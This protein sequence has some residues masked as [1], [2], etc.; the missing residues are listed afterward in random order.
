MVAPAR[1]RA[2]VPRI[3]GAGGTA[4][5]NVHVDWMLGILE[6]IAQEL[7]EDLRGVAIY[8]EQDVT[9]LAECLAAGRIE[10]LRHA[11][12]L[13][14]DALER[15]ARVVAMIGVEPLQDALATD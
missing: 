11:P 1:P 14:P 8:C 9:Y 4:G 13:E 10:P 7:G 6:E 12:E 2:R 3:V 15:C 5:A